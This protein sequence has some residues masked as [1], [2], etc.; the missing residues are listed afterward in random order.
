M[1]VVS[2]KY[3]LTIFSKRLFYYHLIKEKKAPYLFLS[4]PLLAQK[5]IHIERDL[6]T[7][8]GD[9]RV[10]EGHWRIQANRDMWKMNIDGGGVGEWSHIPR[11]AMDLSVRLARDLNAN[12]VNLDLMESQGKFLLSEFSPVWH[13]YAYKEKPTFVYKENYNVDVPLEESLDLERII[14]ESLLANVRK[15]RGRE[16][17]KK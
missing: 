9:G 12:W 8:V 15:A 11:E 4:T 17:E 3:F 6:K 2:L 5:F 1:S 16:R 10:V 13:H 7:V 14:I